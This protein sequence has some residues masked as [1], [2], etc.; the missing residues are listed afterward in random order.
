[1]SDMQPDELLDKWFESDAWK[2]ITSDGLNG[3]E[4]S[5]ILMENVNDQLNNLIFHLSNDSDPKRIGYELDY[6]VN[7]CVDFGVEL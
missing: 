2:Q 3:C 4:D 7:L 6:F 1:M 5:L